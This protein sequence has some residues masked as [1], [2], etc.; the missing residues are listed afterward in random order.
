[1]NAAP[2]TILPVPVFLNRFAAPRCVFSFGI[3]ISLLEF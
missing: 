3:V 2:R 1:L